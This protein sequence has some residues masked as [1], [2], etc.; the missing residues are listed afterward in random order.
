VKKQDTTGWAERKH[1]TD[2]FHTFV[3]LS[4][5]KD[6]LAIV[7]QGLREYEAVDD[8]Q[9]ALAIT[10]LR[11]VRCV[12]YLVAPEHEEMDGAQ[13]LG[14]HTAR[15]AI[16][17]HSGR[18]TDAQLYRE[19]FGHNVPLKAIQH[20][21]THGAA[22]R[23]LS[24]FSVGSANIVL[25][26]MKKAETRDSLIVRLCNPTNQAIETTL[27]S[28]FPLSRIQ[29]LNLLEEPQGEA[30]LTDPHTARLTIGA[31]KI[32]TLELVPKP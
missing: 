11:S 21:R 16:V 2:P 13:C 20:S 4:D 6:G 17:A 29:T 22:P 14:P 5:G 28:H 7:A 15:Y 8:A 1:P 19:A 27:K 30:P 18:W 12:T 24:F 10:L 3:G 9:R 32:A 26:A 31:K 23:E 25:S